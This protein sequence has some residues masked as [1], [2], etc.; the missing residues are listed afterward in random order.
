MAKHLALV[1]PELSTFVRSEL[2]DRAVSSV[3]ALVVLFFPE[4]R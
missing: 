3:E 2:M 1:H 4:G